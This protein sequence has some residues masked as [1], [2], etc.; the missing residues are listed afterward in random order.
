MSQIIRGLMRD[1]KSSLARRIVYEAMAKAAA[2]LTESQKSEIGEYSDVRE[3][4]VLFVIDR[5]HTKC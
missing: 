2:R 3:K 5:H 1:G 4:E